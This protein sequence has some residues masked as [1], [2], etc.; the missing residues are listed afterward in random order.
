MVHKKGVDSFFLVITIV[1]GLKKKGSNRCEQVSE[2]YK[3]LPLL[4]LL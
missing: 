1:D 3:V 4:L 2:V